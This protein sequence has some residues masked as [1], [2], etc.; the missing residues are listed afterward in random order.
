MPAN[1]RLCSGSAGIK[2]IL[3]GELAHPS[4]WDKQR[5]SQYQQHRGAERDP[6]LFRQRQR[7]QVQENQNPVINFP[8]LFQ[9]RSK[10]SV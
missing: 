4:V 5:Q 7:R 6:A 2:P 1:Q 10:N 8:Y 9:H 3:P